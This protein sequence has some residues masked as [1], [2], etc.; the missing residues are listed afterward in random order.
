[1]HR[2]ELTCLQVAYSE[3]L[4]LEEQQEFNTW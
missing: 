1:M 2:T 4:A 3:C